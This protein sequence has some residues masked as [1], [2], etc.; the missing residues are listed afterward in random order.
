MKNNNVF[1]CPNC[2][3]TIPFIEEITFNEK[4]ECIYKLNC[5]CG[6]RTISL[7][8]LAKQLKDNK[9]QS[10]ICYNK[11][12]NNPKTSSLFC[13]QCS[14]WYCTKCSKIHRDDLS[15]NYFPC[16]VNS[17]II[18]NKHQEEESI[19]FCYGCNMLLCEKCTKENIHLNHKIVS[20]K[21]NIAIITKE[22]IETEKIHWI[23]KINECKIQCNEMIN[24]INGL[25]KI[26]LDYRNLISTKSNQ[27]KELLEAQSVISQNIKNNTYVLSNNYI[28]ANNYLLIKNIES[29]NLSNFFDKNTYINLKNTIEKQ[30]NE[31]A[32]ISILKVNNVMNKDSFSLSKIEQTETKF[33]ISNE[34]NLF[35]DK[36]KDSSM[37]H[38]IIYNNITN[39]QA[40]S[41]H[42]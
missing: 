18:C 10:G 19:Y 16:E 39:S 36:E 27:F 37:T 34:S 38:S 12:H 5:S 3:N 1:L 40:S 14:R 7:L 28:N 42:L 13:S 22:E 31:F 35:S 26:L 15:H 23:Q 24:T 29:M 6:L 25:V 33:N 17:K 20:M 2:N 8:S 41:I 11:N 32:N 21:N 30:R 9:A 4:N